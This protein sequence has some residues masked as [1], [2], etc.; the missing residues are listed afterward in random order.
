[1]P[2]RTDTLHLVAVSRGR[3][4]PWSVKGIE[5]V[6]LETCFS[7]EACHSLQLW[8][9]HFKKTIEELWQAE[10]NWMMFRVNWVLYLWTCW[11]IVGIS[12]RKSC[13]HWIMLSHML[14]EWTS[15]WCL[16]VEIG[17]LDP[18][19][20]KKPCPSAIQVESSQSI[21]ATWQHI[22]SSWDALD[23]RE[24]WSCEFTELVVASSFS[25]PFKG[26]QCS[27]GRECCITTNHFCQSYWYWFV[28][29]AFLTTPGF[30]CSKTEEKQARELF[31]QEWEAFEEECRGPGSPA[32]GTVVPQNHGK[33][34]MHNSSKNQ[35]VWGIILSCTIM[36]QNT[37][38]HW[39]FADLSDP[40]SRGY[41]GWSPKMS[42]VSKNK[43]D[44]IF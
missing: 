22:A 23:A 42:L 26:L 20:G 25:D 19:L 14:Y 2:G 38:L 5:G 15:A 41:C 21:A 27:V 11:N 7:R 40:K 29:Y 1:M 13:C 3:C 12:S 44:T 10:W 36:C 39:H 16:M 30:S 37:Y 35:A 17:I 18:N 32:F 8:K 33:L 6:H 28:R 9:V 34:K 43:R 31:N 4:W 24:Y